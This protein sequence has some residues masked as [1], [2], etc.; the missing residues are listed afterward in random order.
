MDLA[1]Y[2]DLPGPS[3]A[4]RRLGLP[5][6]FTAVYTGQFYAG[7][8]LELMAE[9]ARRNPEVSF[10][11]AG[12]D[13]ETLA[14]W[15]ERLEQEGLGNVRLLGYRPHAEVPLIQAA[16]DVL[17]MPYG[18]R[19]AVSGGGDTAAVASPMKA[20]EYLAAGRPILASDLPVFREVLDEA[21]A[22]LLPP[23]E[24]ETWDEALKALQEDPARR[25][26]LAQAARCTAQRYSWQARQARALAGMEEGAGEAA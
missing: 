6:A 10:V 4:R 13:E 26:A 19:V 1:R 15:R 22:V 2:A 24:V 12:G 3:E 5:E 17:L 16:G 14:R 23:E 25:R 8:G 18:R 11:W 20:F 21:N 7:R 9:L